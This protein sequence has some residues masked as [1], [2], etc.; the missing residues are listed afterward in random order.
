MSRPP[1]PRERKRHCY[2]YIS[3]RYRLRQSSPLADKSRGFVGGSCLLQSDHR[4][5]ETGLASPV[6]PSRPDQSHS[7]V[8]HKRYSYATRRLPIMNVCTGLPKRRSYRMSPTSRSIPR[9]LR[10]CWYLYERYGKR[11]PPDRCHTYRSRHNRKTVPDRAS[12]TPKQR[13]F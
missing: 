4:K 13:M 9:S 1:K 3:T 10:P 12:S 5:R 8:S 2:Y 7:S 6:R 11:S